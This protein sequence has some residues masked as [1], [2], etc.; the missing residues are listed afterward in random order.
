[1]PDRQNRSRIDP[2]AIARLAERIEEYQDASQ[3]VTWYWHAGEPLTVGLTHFRACHD[4]LVDAAPILARESFF[5]VQTNGTLIN[6]NWASFFREFKYQVGVSLDG[7][8]DIH[9]ARRVTRSGAGTY[10]QVIAGIKL[11]QAAGVKPAVLAVVGAD[12]LDRGAEI[13]RSF[14]FLGIDNVSFNF[15]EIEGPNLSSSLSA[16]EEGGSLRDGVR[17]FVEDILRERADRFP[18]MV[19]RETDRLVPTLLT[20]APVESVLTQPMTY[21]T[22][23]SDGT[24]STFCPELAG[25]STSLPTVN[26]HR[27]PLIELASRV[28]NS[29]SYAQIHSGVDAC[30]RTCPYF[31]TCGGGNPGNKLFEHGRFDVTETL[32]CRIRNQYVTDAL[33]DYIIAS[34]PD[35]SGRLEAGQELH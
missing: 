23:L 3:P 20:G 32:H 22:V 14:G 17:R 26:I 9:D 18:D 28:I 7:P 15:E 10:S 33:L 16:L 24:A 25:G 12:S 21:L 35:A 11:L 30:R 31:K 27:E 4:A 13:L 5:H 1:L 8:A 19:L 34:A 29:D 6:D 2:A